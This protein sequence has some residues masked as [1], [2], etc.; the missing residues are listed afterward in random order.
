MAEAIDRPFVH[1]TSDNWDQV[2]MGRD[3]QG[4]GAAICKIASLC[5]P[6]D[7]I[8]GDAP[9]GTSAHLAGFSA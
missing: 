7:P 5:L 6:N 3:P 8:P 9:V 2:G 1:V 4:A